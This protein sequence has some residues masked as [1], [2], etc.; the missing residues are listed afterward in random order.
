MK[1]TQRFRADNNGL[2]GAVDLIRELLKKNGIKE[3]ELISA[4]LSSEEAIASLLE[5][6][7]KDSTFTLSV[8]GFLGTVSI[9][10]VSEGE[11]Y[12]PATSISGSSVDLDEETGALAQ[13]EIRRILLKAY[14]KDLR[15]SHRAGKNTIR[16]TVV[17]SR[18]KNIYLT[19]GAMIIAILVGLFLANCADPEF[20]KTLDSIVLSPVKTMYMNALKM[21]VAPVVFF[22]IISCVVKFSDLSELGRIGGKIMVYYMLTTIVAVGVGLGAYYL[23]QPGSPADMSQLA[24]ASSI[25]SQTMDVSIID[26]I[27][28]IIPSNFLRPFLE[29]DMLQLIFMAVL[30]GIG[31]GMIGRYSALLKDII[32]AMN[33][34]FLKVTIIIIRFMPLAVFCSVASAML[35]LGA[36]TLLSMLAMLGTFVFGLVCMMCVYCLLIMIR[37]R[38]NPFTFLKK[39]LPTMLQVFS[40]ASS[41]AS[42]PINMDACGKKLGIAQKVYSLSIPL[43]ATL[44]M[45]GTCVHLAVFSMALAKIYGVEI[46]GAAILSLITTIIVLSVSAPGIP[47]AGLICLSVL[48]TQIGVPVESIGLVMGI[49]SLVGMFRCM[50]N[51]LGDVA[52]STVV[53]K[54]EGLLDTKIYNS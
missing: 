52:V 43:G 21:V 20:N 51:C 2:E 28:G 33:E 23:F 13:D 26:T 14:T 54:S 16:M 48:I 22:S 34:L 30:F 44:N 5:H 11:E 12:D 6:A 47:G 17:R 7:K 10:I 38:L 32:E 8:R 24:D 45:D 27:V 31:V 3:K 25:T 41:N 49:D 4:Q 50:S 39:Y 53:A 9:C 29:S 18:T 46:T 36:E 37:A 42:I 1:I 15:F 35:T 40:M 19:L